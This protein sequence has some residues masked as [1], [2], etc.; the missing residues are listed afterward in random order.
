M[1]GRT[2]TQAPQEGLGMSRPARPRFIRQ[3]RRPLRRR[4]RP[5]T[6]QEARRRLFRRLLDRY[7]EELSTWMLRDGVLDPIVTI[8]AVD[9]VLAA[10]V[11]ACDPDSACAVF[12][13]VE[14]WAI[15]NVRQWLR[16]LMA[17]ELAARPAAGSKARPNT[18]A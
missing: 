1:G 17:R 14:G 16:R 5:L 13:R 12:L 9:H 7:A 10:V 6:V 4:K 2:K 18:A 8:D 11:R 3:R 15:T